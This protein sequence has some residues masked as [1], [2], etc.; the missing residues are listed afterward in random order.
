MPRPKKVLTAAIPEGEMVEQQKIT[1]SR[2]GLATIPGVQTNIV[3][4]LL[5]GTVPLIVHNFSEKLRKQILAKHMGEASRGRERKDPEANFNA[6]RHRLA[7]G[8]DGFPAGGI[9]AAIVGGFGRDV[10]VFLKTAK[11]AIR[12]AADCPATNL[13]RII[14]PEGQPT[15]R[16]DPCKNETGVVDIRHRPQYWPWAI[17]LRVEHVPEM[18]SELQ[19]LQAI[20]RAGFTC[21]LGEWRPSSPKSYS[22]SFGTWRLAEPDEIDLYESGRLFDQQLPS[23]RRRALERA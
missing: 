2:T 7:N 16:E 3:S 22:G 10:G 12:V 13:V 9:K 21:G 14:A 17:H 8:E 23:R 18:L 5:I 20:A 1:A 11:G 4:T 6:A 19:V 15:M